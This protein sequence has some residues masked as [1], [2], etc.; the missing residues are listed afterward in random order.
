MIE[1]DTITMFH[2][3]QAKQILKEVIERDK[4]E[5]QIGFYNTKIKDLNTK[6]Q[7]LEKVVETKDKT[8][9]ILIKQSD[10]Y[11]DIIEIKNLQIKE[12]E[13]QNRKRKIRNGF[14]IGGAVSISATFI[15]LEI[16][17]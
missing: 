11:K 1:G 5:E 12:Y 14:L 9:S 2:F 13:K 8:E 15:I 16:I 7:L 6:I 17:K 10:I 3:W 4:Y